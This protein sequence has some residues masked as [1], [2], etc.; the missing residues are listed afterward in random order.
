MVKTHSIVDSDGDGYTTEED[1]DDSNELVS[2]EA[3]ELCDGVDNNCDGQVDEGVTQ[4]YFSDADQDGF[5]D[6]EST[7]QACESPAGTVPNGNDCDDSNPA[8]YP[9]TTES[10]DG[11]DNNCDGSIDEGVGDPYYEDADADTTALVM[12]SVL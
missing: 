10:C 3:E 9:G 6:P 1:C 8:V 4:T 12:P 5:G 11:I 2:P 7:I